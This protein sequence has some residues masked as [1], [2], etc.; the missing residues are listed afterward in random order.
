MGLAHPKVLCFAAV[1][2]FVCGLAVS[3][4]RTPATVSAH[5]DSKVEGAELFATRGCTHCHG[6]D[7]QGTDSGPSLRQLRKKLSSEQI[8]RQIVAGGQAM[9]AFGDTL[10]HEQVASLVAF[11]KAKK[12]ISAPAAATAV[13]SH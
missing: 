2:L 13:P 10:D 9:P 11:L 6:V 3:A 7:G 5:A 8:E 12:W 4:L 1:P